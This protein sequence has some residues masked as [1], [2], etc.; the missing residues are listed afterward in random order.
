MEDQIAK[1]KADLLEFDKQG[2]ADLT[3]NRNE[4]IR[5]IL[6]EIEKIVSNFA[7]KEDYSIILNDRVLIYGVPKDDVT[8]YILKT[9][10]AAK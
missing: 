7:Q 5:E 3:K 4:K 6:L 8:E 1:I 2:K 9:L 10:N